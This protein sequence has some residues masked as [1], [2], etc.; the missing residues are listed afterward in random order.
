VILNLKYSIFSVYIVSFQQVFLKYHSDR[1]SFS[2]SLHQI[3][4]ANTFS[5]YESAAAMAGAQWLLE[6]LR[7]KGPSTLVGV[8]VGSMASGAAFGAIQGITA[9]CGGVA[10]TEVA[11][12]ALCTPAG[13]L[14]AI[15]LGILC[16]GM[17]RT[18]NTARFC[19]YTRIVIKI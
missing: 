8:G 14:I 4:M 11:A 17:C 7:S 12:A 10:A 1:R 5:I 19:T 6:E 15:G 16:A 18:Q 2:L 13:P 9:Y 3:L